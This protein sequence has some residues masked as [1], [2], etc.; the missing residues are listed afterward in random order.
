[1]RQHHLV[2]FNGDSVWMIQVYLGLDEAVV[3]M[4][5]AQVGML[6]DSYT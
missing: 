4:Q 1:M 3:K 2:G 5:C 6:F